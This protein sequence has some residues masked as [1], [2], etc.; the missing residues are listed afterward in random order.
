[1]LTKIVITQGKKKKVLV[2][3]TKKY[4]SIDYLE[5]A[6]NEYAEREGW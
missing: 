5:Y 4:V 1:M 6:I 3:K 2:Y